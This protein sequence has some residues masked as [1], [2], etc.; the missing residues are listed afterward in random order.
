MNELERTLDNL[1]KEYDTK[2]EELIPTT[3][4]AK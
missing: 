4:I 1:F 3:G 2:P